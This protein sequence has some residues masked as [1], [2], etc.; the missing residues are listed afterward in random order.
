MEYRFELPPSQQRV[1]ERLKTAL[2]SGGFP[3]ALLITGGAGVGKRALAMQLA[4]ALTCVDDEVRPCGKCPYCRAVRPEKGES[5]WLWVVPLAGDAEKLEKEEVRLELTQKAVAPSMVDPWDVEAFPSKGTVRVE[6]VRDVLRELG[7]KDVR[8]R[9][10]LVPEAD[11]MAA[12]SA[13]AL[14]KTLEE[15]PENC[16]F[17]LTTSHAADLLPT[18]LSRCA[19]IHLPDA[20]VAEVGEFLERRGISVERLDQLWALA[21][22]SPGQAALMSRESVASAR[23]LAMGLLEWTAA[24]T[25]LDLAGWW[26]DFSAARK[27]SET[28]EETP[29][30]VVS[31]L[32]S[33]LDDLMRIVSGLPVRNSEYEERLRALPFARRGADV[34]RFMHSELLKMERHLGH[35]VAPE[36]VF[37]ALALKWRNDSPRLD[38]SLASEEPR[39]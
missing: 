33:L 31:A 39:K 25:S 26:S 23:S 15:V 7:R 8:T 12:S 30:F 9:V 36:R 14:L 3:Q 22:G 20:T 35:S 18:V 10:V 21:G 13:N 24:D 6:S 29:R 2:E 4:R 37:L 1:A 11:R 34:V 16:Y 27:K 32:A 38:L 19:K 5:P 17:V 28:D